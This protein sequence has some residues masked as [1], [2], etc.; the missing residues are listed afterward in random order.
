MPYAFFLVFLFPRAFFRCG[1][2][3]SNVFGDVGAA[4][5]GYGFF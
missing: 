5:E 3:F 2:D 1:D 4:E